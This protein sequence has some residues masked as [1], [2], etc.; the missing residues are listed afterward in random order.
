MNAEKI[1]AMFLIAYQ[2]KHLDKRLCAP[3]EV[4]VQRWRGAGSCVSWWLCLQVI[5]WYLHCN[6]KTTEELL[7]EGISFHEKGE[8]RHGF[9][10]TWGDCA[11]TTGLACSERHPSP[12]ADPAPVHQHSRTGVNGTIQLLKC[13]LCFAIIVCCDFAPVYQKLVQPGVW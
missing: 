7:G 12:T 9:N 2:N 1:L 8:N 10:P 11:K 13:A 6:V 4:D 3:A 5:V